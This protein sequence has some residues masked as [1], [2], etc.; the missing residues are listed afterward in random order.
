L[1]G[2]NVTK[3]CSPIALITGFGGACAQIFDV[4]SKKVEKLLSRDGKVIFTAPYFSTTAFARDRSANSG[5]GGTDLWN[6]CRLP[7][8]DLRL[9]PFER[10]RFHTRSAVVAVSIAA[11]DQVLIVGISKKAPVIPIDLSRIAAGNRGEYTEL[12]PRLDVFSESRAACG[13]PKI[14]GRRC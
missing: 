10:D 6:L 3:K 2:R 11:P 4:S 14:P 7:F 9:V 5:V 8:P 12:S 1:P 13:L